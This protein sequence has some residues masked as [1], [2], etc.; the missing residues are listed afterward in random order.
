MKVKPVLVYGISHKKEAFSWRMW[1]GIQTEEDV[2]EEIQRVQKE[3]EKLAMD[4][5]FPIEIMPL[6]KVKTV[7]EAYGVGDIGSSDAVLVYAAGGHISQDVQVT[8]GKFSK[9]LLDHYYGTMRNPLEALLSFGR[10]CIFFIR[11]KSGPLYMWY[12]VIH[13]HFLRK[14]SRDDFCQLGANIDDVVVDDY[15]KVLWRLRS[16]YGLK[17]TLGKK[18]ISIGE[19]GGWGIGGKAVKIAEDKWNLDIK[20]VSNQELGEMIERAKKDRSAIERARQRADELLLDEKVSLETKREFVVNSALFY[21]VLEELLKKFKAEAITIK[22]CMTTIIPATETTACLPL[23]MLNDAGYLALCESD[24][25]TMPAG[26]LLHH[27]SGKP[28]FFGDPTY[29]HDGMVTLAHCT[30]PRKMD[31]LVHER[32]K[33]TTHFESDYGA[34]PKV[35][36]RKG[37]EVTI[38]DPAFSGE[39]WVGFKGRILDSPSLPI[40]RSQVEIEIVGDWKNLLE[41]MRGFHWV[42]VYGDYLKEVG[43]VLRKRG[44]KWINISSK[45]SR[46]GRALLCA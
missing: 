25:V 14:S 8:S 36:M 3:L 31:G 32:T 27:V 24:F 28:V 7:D 20:T 46:G 21:G 38:I 44:I 23:S 29:P 35:E 45:A 40:C 30:A 12:E 33:I 43:Y 6:S 16:L 41:E 13:P 4:A 42:M 11:H 34:A 1:G 19:P 17:E 2:N 26:I 18:I 22:D 15:E 39:T 5:E 9:E 10:P 37:Q